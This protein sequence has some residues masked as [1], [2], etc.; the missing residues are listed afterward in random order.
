[1]EEKN[2]I[3]NHSN[4][5]VLRGQHGSLIQSVFAHDDR[6]T[7]TRLENTLYVYGTYSGYITFSG[8]K[9]DYIVIDENVLPASL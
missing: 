8:I 3:N 5:L 2:R 4:W 9:S 1:M 7:L 6:E